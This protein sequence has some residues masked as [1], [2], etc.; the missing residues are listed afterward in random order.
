MVTCNSSAMSRRRRIR[1]DV[2]ACC[3]CPSR[4]VY[5]CSSK[6]TDVSRGSKIARDKEWMLRR[7]SCSIAVDAR[8]G[9]RTA[10]GS[11]YNQ[12]VAI[13]PATA[14]V[15]RCHCTHALGQFQK[16]QRPIS[17]PTQAQNIPF[18][19][20]FKHLAACTSILP[21]PSSVSLRH[22]SPLHLGCI[23]SHCIS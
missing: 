12:W 16:A 22:L 7:M 19:R 18:L 10:H 23:H 6:P 14:A 3:G 15:Y 5:H 17:R 2:P 20:N 1:A 4:C 21:L 9:S 13:S 8:R 11:G